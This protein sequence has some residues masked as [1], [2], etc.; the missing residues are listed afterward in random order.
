MIYLFYIVT[1][2]GVAVFKTSIVPQVPLFYGFYDILLLFVI[3]FGFYRTIRES[4]VFIAFFGLAMDAVSGGPFGL[5]TT[6]YLWLYAFVLWLTQ[7]MRVTNSMI[8]PLV[9]I[10]S[11]I[12]QNAIF[13][14]SMTLLQTTAVL[15]SDSLQVVLTQIAWGAFTGPIIILLLRHLSLKLGKWQRRFQTDMG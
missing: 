10:C 8:L 11:V 7:F 12:I 1:F 14:G 3:F 6:S 5:Y 2:L 13:L 15:P 4:L 9:V